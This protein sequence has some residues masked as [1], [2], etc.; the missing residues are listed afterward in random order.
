MVVIE[1]PKLAFLDLSNGADIENLSQDKAA[2][3]PAFSSVLVQTTKTPQ[4]DVLF[5]YCILEA[6]GTIRGSNQRLA[7]I[8]RE[9]GARIAVVASENPGNSYIAASKSQKAGPVNFVMTVERKGSAFPEFFGRLFALMYGGTEMP[10]AW[11]K[12][13]PQIPHAEHTQC[14]G[15]ICAM[16]AGGIVFRRTGAAPESGGLFGAVRS[17]FK[18]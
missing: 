12:L 5:L 15:T 17:L 2:L 7:T 9:S 13:A 6:D 3:E 8:I 14:P 4:C 16:A 11:N 1:S 18:R 10:V